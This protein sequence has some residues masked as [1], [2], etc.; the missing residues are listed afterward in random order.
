[1]GR[2]G[3]S[4]RRRE[5]A[6]DHEDAIRRELAEEVGLGAFSLGPLIW[7]R[8][9]LFELDEW[10]GQVERYYLVRTEAF[11]PAPGLTWTELNAEYVTDLRWW[12][13]EELET[14]PGQFAPRG[15]PLLVRRL[16]QQGP[17]SEPIDVGV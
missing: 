15:L 12:A 3:D 5:L 13:L 1:L 16:T 8:T 11:A 14:F 2:L 6:R 4:R 9:H 7:A 10:D 17:P